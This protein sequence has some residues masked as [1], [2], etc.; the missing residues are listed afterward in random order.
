VTRRPRPESPGAAGPVSAAASLGFE[1]T[2]GDLATVAAICD[3]VEGL[4]LAVEL[5]AAR[6]RPLTPAEP[7]SRLGRPLEVLAGGAADLPDRHQSL[8]ATIV[9]SL[10]ML[11]D[12]ARTLFAWMGA[13]GADVR[14]DD[15][16]RFFARLAASPPLDALAELVDSSM[17]HVRRVG[18]VSRYVTADPVRE[19]A[20]ELLAGRA[21]RRDA[22]HA[23]AE[24]YPDRLRSVAAHHDGAAFAD[25]DADADNVRVAPAWAQRHD[26]AMVDQSS[27]EAMYR[28]RE[29]RGRFVEVARAT[30]LAAEDWCTAGRALHNLGSIL[31]LIGDYAR[32]EAHY[33]QALALRRRVRALVGTQPTA[34]SEVRAARGALTDTAVAGLACR[35]P[36]VAVGRNQ[37]T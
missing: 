26:P 37:A 1:P 17:P 3:A 24:I 10:E 9:A 28:Y 32:A 31:N 18:A 11:V 21:D 15:L 27:V 23:V 36:P 5:A 19:L 13:S 34:S 20:R 14:V 29:Q 2:D 16:D 35:E 25:L 12:P 30:A 8:R 7:L 33:L 22:E 4:P 6:L